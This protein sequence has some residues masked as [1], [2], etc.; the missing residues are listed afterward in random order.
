MM[1]TLRFPDGMQ[2]DYQ[3]ERRARKTIGLKIDSS[4]LVVHAPQR[5]SHSRLEEML[6]QKAGWIQKKMRQMAANKPAPMV[7]QDGTELYLLGE[8]ITLRLQQATRRQRVAFA[9][10]VLRLEL[11]APNDS[12]VIASKVMQWYKAAALPDFTRRLE[13]FAARL[14]EKCPPLYLSSARQRWGSC[15]S[16]REIRINWRLLQAPPHII[17]YVICHELA[18]LREMNHSARFWAVVAELYP[19]YRQAEQELRARAA[20]LHLIQKLS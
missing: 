6:L 12:A 17:D 9:D 18:H 15:N 10:S 13:W 5:I 16:K 4:G 8:P 20:Q 19:D 11:H 2:L 7:W 14:G 3:L 1:H